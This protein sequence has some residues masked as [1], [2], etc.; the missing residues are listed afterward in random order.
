MLRRV[1]NVSI[2]V[3]SRCNL[4]CAHCYNSSGGAG[5][6][7]MSKD[8]ILQVAGQVADIRPDGVCLC[9]G[10]PLLCPDIYDIMDAL[11]KGAESIS[12]VSNGLLITDRVAAELKVHGLRTI[13]ISLDGAY[14]W[15]HDSLRGL[16]GAFDA[17]KRAIV[18]LIKA[19]IEQVFVSMIPN[20]LNYN[21]LDEYFALCYSLGITMIKCM[22]FMPMG[23]GGA[24]GR[25]LILSGAEMLRFQLRLFALKEQYEGVINV[26][27]DDPVLTARYL[28]ERIQQGK[29]PLMLCI[30]ADGDVCTDVYAPVRLGSLRHSSLETLCDEALA[31]VRD[32]GRFTEILDKLHEINDLGGVIT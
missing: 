9:G 2:D 5:A 11:S 12:M 28:C 25:S 1:K 18:S 19:G 32:Q 21:T 23:R 31:A 6:G 17:A 15:Q 26:E 3:T 14:A 30:N 20:K 24:V 27:W 4:C 16:A 22:P 29:P 10:E 7:D 13:Q 8:E